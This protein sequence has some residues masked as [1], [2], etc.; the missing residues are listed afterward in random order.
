[1]P[2]G[3]TATWSSDGGSQDAG[4][5]ICAAPAPPTS[6]SYFSITSGFAFC[7]LSND[8]N[9]V[10]TGP[11]NC[12]H[13]LARP[14]AAERGHAACATLPTVCVCVCVCVCGPARRAH[15]RARWWR[16]GC[17]LSV[18]LRRS[19]V[20]VVCLV[21]AVTV[22]LVG[23]VMALDGPIAD[24]DNEACT[25]TAV[26]PLTLTATSFATEECCDTLTI[27]GSQ[28]SGTTGPTAVP[29]TPGVTTASWSSDGSGDDAGWTVCATGSSVSSPPP[30][31]PSTSTFWTITSGAEYCQLSNGGAC[32]T[33][34]PGDCMRRAHARSLVAS[35]TRIVQHAHVH[36][37]VHVHVHVTH[38]LA[39]CLSQ[40]ATTRHAQSLQTSS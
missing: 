17:P 13:P 38:A 15:S 18:D 37:H 4:W 23:L 5:T 3:S 25:F 20:R 16:V 30:P 26:Q 39:R 29:M 2:A 10:T 14:C 33:D 27:G 36:A 21:I 11:G 32:I 40:T 6:S 28:Y 9:C 34:G 12:A 1:M 19:F 35:L 24:G 22:V 31:P 7:G 8:G